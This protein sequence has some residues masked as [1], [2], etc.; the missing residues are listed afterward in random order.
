MGAEQDVEVFDVQDF[1]KEQRVEDQD[2]PWVVVE[3]AYCCAEEGVGGFHL[4]EAWRAVEGGMLSGA[5]DS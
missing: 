1:V 3:G 2:V 4:G 5:E